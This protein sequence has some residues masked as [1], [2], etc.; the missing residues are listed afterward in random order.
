[1]RRISTEK[2]INCL[3]DATIIGDKLKLLLVIWSEE[4]INDQFSK[5][6]ENKEQT[7]IRHTQDNGK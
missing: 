1:M 7:I 3:L 5:R 2:R 6:A 4:N